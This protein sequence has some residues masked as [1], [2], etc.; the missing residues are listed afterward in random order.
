MAEYDAVVVGSGPN[1]FAA[2]ITLARM[3][4]KVLLLE[5]KP[6]IGG[7][8]R[9]LELTL[10]GFQH[11][12]CSS[13]HPLGIASPF[14]RSLP[15]QDFG[16]SWVFPDAEVA[17][18][19]DN[20]EVITVERSIE[21][22]AAQLGRD[23]QQYQRLMTPLV[24]NYE[25]VLDEFLGPLRI[26]HHPLVMAAF[27]MLAIQSASGLAKLAFSEAQSRAMFAGMAAHSI[28][29]LENIATAAFGLMMG[30]LAHAIGW[31][32]ARGGSQ[33][34]A[35]ALAR[36]FESLGGETVTNCEV[37]TLADLPPARMVLLDVTPR[38][39]LKI[40]GNHLPEGYRRQ[41]E[42]YRYGP[43]VFKID[44]ALSEPIPWQHAATARAATVHLGSSLDDIR[45][46][47]RDAW[48]GKHSSRP[49]TLLVQ[50]TLFDPSR[51]P[52]GKH[53]AWAYCHVPHASSED[54]TE[55]VER[56]IERYAPG[57]C[58]VVLMRRTHHAMAMESY[59][60]NYIG[61]DINGGVQDLGQLFTR[62]TR[63]IVPYS[64][65]LEH[66]FL[67]SSSTPPG[68]G[69]HGMCGYHAALAASAAQ[70]RHT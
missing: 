30:M 37:H 56:Q 32:L 65:P 43:G 58:D 48:Q 34:I 20:G 3:G 17:H 67:C 62:P 44:Y 70:F 51:A 19:L 45:A 9:T 5:A 64:T 7:G 69:V 33:S 1:G 21:A 50:P 14:F 59:N 6:T 27:G 31:P 53:I 54:M 68:G 4:A 13:I 10:P 28:M 49:F 52:T 63:R 66:L 29:P 23:R 36:Y 8:M 25:K 57:F 15:L 61:G 26:P 2:G 35:N 24:N 22:T 38:Q 18:P 46:S 40:A 55:A 60:S 39:L 16:L 42:A 47:E 11:D 41:L 12:M